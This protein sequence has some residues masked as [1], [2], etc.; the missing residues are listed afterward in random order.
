MMNSSFLTWGQ[1]LLGSF[2]L[3]QT[4]LLI[5]QFGVPRDTVRVLGVLLSFSLSVS[6][7]AEGVA[8]F[9][10]FPIFH[11]E[12][13]YGVVAGILALS[14]IGFTYLGVV[15]HPG[16]IQ[17]KIMW[18]LPLLGGL[19]GQW[20]NLDFMLLVLFA[21]WLCTFGYFVTVA[22]SH[23]YALRIFIAQLFLGAVGFGFLKI[24]WWPGVQLVCFLWI[25]LFHRFLNA[26]MVK[27]LARN[28]LPAPIEGAQ[29]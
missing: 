14:L 17:R 2:S 16:Q 7:L 19:V 25:L 22:D 3:A 26:Y 12:S 11:F 8:I 13:L 27:N 4:A 10:F 24:D 9:G 1:F 29:A 15:D 5:L 20:M 23:R 21:G 28:F 6:F 18:R